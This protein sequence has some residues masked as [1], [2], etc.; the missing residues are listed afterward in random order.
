MV[1]STKKR[2]GKQRKAAKNREA[3]AQPTT[4]G[5]ND[6]SGGVDKEF[7][8]FWGD[9]Q[10]YRKAFNTLPP[11]KIINDIK[12]GDYT[13]T[14]MAADLTD[15]ADNVCRDRLI[16]AGIVPVILG[17]L[18]RCH[19]ELPFPNVY[20][21]QWMR[22]LCTFGEPSFDVQYAESM[23][24]II[25]CLS[26][27]RKRQF[28]QSNMFWHFSIPDFLTMASNVIRTEAALKIMLSYEGFLEPCIL[29]TTPC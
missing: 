14:E 15:E 25:Q 5:T 12:R 6:G 4:T 1:S 24:P 16:N 9:D 8:E 23:G 11:E 10:R 26:N 3:A 22:M 20:P 18:V 27:D 2:R 21:N 7:E 19:E 28:F 17:L 13:A 29:Q